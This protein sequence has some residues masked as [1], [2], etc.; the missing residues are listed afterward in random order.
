MSS[1]SPKNK[2]SIYV[3]ENL[4]R[5]IEGGSNL[6]VEKLTDEELE[7]MHELLLEGKAEIISLACRPY[8]SAKQERFIISH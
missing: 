5:K 7:A 1:K 6:L 8:L 2:K 3:F 4:R